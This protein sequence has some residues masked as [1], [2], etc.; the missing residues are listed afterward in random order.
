MAPMSRH[1]EVMAA[2]AGAVGPV[3][4]VADH[5]W[6]LAEAVVVELATDAGSRV[7]AKG[8]TE[9][10]RFER[11]VAAYDQW[12]PAIAD[13]APRLLAVNDELG[14]I[15]IER[16]DGIAPPTRF[17]DPA[18]ERTVHRGAAQV[19]R[20]FHDAQAAEALPGWAEARIAGLEAWIARAPEGLLD[21]RDI[22]FARQQVAQL[23]QFPDPR[24]VPCHG[25]WQ[26]RNWIIA[27]S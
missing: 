10:L 2:A 27:T 20:R 22:G 18:A 26:P 25:D 24:G 12:V 19:L 23:V 21:P 4:I 14:V 16:V 6:D 1:E 8:H 15:I 5:S 9:R 3:T 13:R 11:E 17:D 7:M